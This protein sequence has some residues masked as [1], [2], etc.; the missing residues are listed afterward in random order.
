MLSR[1]ST[2]CFTEAFDPV[3]ALRLIE[4]EQ[5][6]AIFGVSA[7]LRDVTTL[8]RG[9]GYDFSSVRIVSGSDPA[10][11]E[12]LR[13]LCPNVKTLNTYGLTEAHCT[14]A[15]AGPDDPAELQRRTCGRFYDGIEYKVVDPITKHE[16]GPGEVGEVLLRG[17]VMRGY[18]DKPE[19]TAKAI[20]DD[21]WL[22]TEDL[23][24][25]DENGYVTYVGRLKAMLKTGGEN[26]AAE[27]VEA[28]ILGHRAVLEC[29]DVGIAHPRK[30]QVGRAYVVARPGMIVSAEEL[31]AWCDDRLARFKVPAEFVFVE[32]LPHTGNDKIDRA[33]VQ[34]IAG[35]SVSIAVES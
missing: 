31:T 19:Q 26:V 5:C 7:M 16:L 24:S 14:V 22:H 12:E 9:G 25:V 1:G 3:S 11:V 20:D 18:W 34:K 8:I 13:E 21:G 2:L 35:G 10:L 33:A 4:R 32:S 6:A 30:D 28:C 27:E 29:V 23:I 17:S 15:A